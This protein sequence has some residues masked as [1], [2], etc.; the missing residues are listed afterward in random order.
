M[1]GDSWRQFATLRAFYAFMWAYPGKKLLF[2][3]QEFAQRREWAFLADL[4]W[5]ALD[6][7]VHRG[8]QA[9][10][11]DCNAAYRKHAALHDGDCVAGGFHWIVVDDARHSVFAWLR[12]DRGAGA[13]VAVVANFT[14]AP[15]QGYRIGLPR[16]GR[17]REI[18]NTDS[19]HYDGSN[20]GNAG[21]VIAVATP[22]HG[23]EFSAKITVPPLGTLW[24]LHD[25]E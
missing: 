6:V 18:L 16:S 15:H 13:P 7:P 5:P 8:M 9:V 1:N 21:E 12:M 24:L 4:D 22:C 10:V 20:V 23:F 2:M 3:G 25:G 17:W 11:R 14:P 19:A